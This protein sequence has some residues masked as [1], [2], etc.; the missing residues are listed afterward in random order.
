MTEAEYLTEHGP[1]LL[2]ELLKQR[3]KLV[4]QLA[5]PKAIGELEE[6]SA[7]RIIARLAAVQS[8][9]AAAREVIEGVK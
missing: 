2:R 3:D 4:A 1:K 5:H 6:Q 8:C 7:D 9:I